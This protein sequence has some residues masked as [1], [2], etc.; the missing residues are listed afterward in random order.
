MYLLGYIFSI[1]MS[2]ESITIV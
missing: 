2:F 1:F